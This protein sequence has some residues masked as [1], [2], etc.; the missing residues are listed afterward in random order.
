MTQQPSGQKQE[1]T[2]MRNRRFWI[3]L[4]TVCTTIAFGLALLLAT[5]GAAAGAA[6]S[7]QET[8]PAQTSEQQTYEGVVTDTHCGAKHE[9]KIS[10][11]AADCARACVHAGSQFALVDGE[12]TYVLSGDMNQLKRAAG[13]RV[14]LTGTRTGDTIAVSAI[15]LGT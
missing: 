13:A 11:T 7:E 5:V 8:A 10:K 6:S 12:T 4:I 9:A 1:L 3:E 14:T 15:T 2:T